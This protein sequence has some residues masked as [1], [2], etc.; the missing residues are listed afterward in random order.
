MTCGLGGGGQNHGFSWWFLVSF[1]GFHYGFLDVFN[2]FESRFLS[3]APFCGFDV[4]FQVFGM[5]F[6]VLS[7][8][9]FQDVCDTKNKLGL[10]SRWFSSMSWGGL[11]IVS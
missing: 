10:L 5:C 3:K 1:T 6:D 4:G 11:V 7:R 9:V 8:L 2:G